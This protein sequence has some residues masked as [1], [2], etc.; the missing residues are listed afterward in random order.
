MKPEKIISCLWGVLLAFLVSF[1]AIA[2]T[3]S[4]FNIRIPLGQAALWCAV[5]AVVCGG[6]F[7]LPLKLV[8]PAVAAAVLG[9]LWRE[10]SLIDS[11]EALLNRLTRQYNRA[12]GWGIIR[13]GFRTADDMEPSMLLVFCIIGAVIA[14]LVAW[15]VCRGKPALPGVLLSFLPVAACFVVTD[16]VPDVKWLYLWMLGVV[17]LILTGKVRRQEE[18]QGNRL[19][20]F[21]APCAAL[22]LLL[23]FAAVP[24]KGYDG[25]KN[26]E[27]MVSALLGS[28]PVQ[29]LMSYTQGNSV[30]SVDSGAVDLRNVGYRMESQAKIMEV[31]AP[32][33]GT[34]Y[35]RGRAMDTYNGISWSDGGNV[36]I[37]TLDWP[38][39]GLESVGEVSVSTRYA[40]R[41]LY[42][43]YYVDTDQL[44]D[45][46]IGIENEK[47]LT[48]Y[49]FPCKV[50]TGAYPVSRADSAFTQEQIDLF[51][52]CIQV[53]E[54]TA[55][56]AVS[57][58]GKL[59]AGTSSVRQ[60]ATNIASYVRNSASYDTATP[61]MPSRD[62][63]FAKWFL[64]ESNT[65]YCVHFATATAVLLQAAGIPARYVTGYMV[66]VQAGQTAEVR[67]D[68]AHAWVE[69][70]QPGFGW[71]VLESTPGDLREQPQ[72]TETVTA[73]TVPEAT[74]QT[75]PDSTT[76]TAHTPV[77]SEKT[78][79]L[80]GLLAA[81]RV[82][83]AITGLVVL[84]EGQHGLRR[85][86]QRKGRSRGST[87]EQAVRCWH[88][89][90]R[91][92]RLLGEQPDKGLFEMAQKAKFSQYTLT[93]QELSQFDDWETAAVG[94]L[95]KRSV[96]HRFWYRI[97]L[98]VY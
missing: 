12:Y 31:T 90:V 91:L 6:C 70:Y 75:A 30:L 13:W 48:S 23:L 51:A 59:T 58:A 27:K 34:L 45:V 33:D 15:A 56:W 67:A 84:L 22:A 86:I 7:A 8:P 29:M 95:K 5:S 38:E 47:K 77:T 4:A 98:A 78:V 42:L 11:V 43:P 87:N 73:A 44:G 49:S 17:V 72:Q 88:H 52:Q 93:Q 9:Y 26:A 35:L 62:R 83:A 55:R 32:F 60:R 71:T 68:Q 66:P 79:D 3:V 64:E 25:Q 54:S 74:E 53:N 50:D 85:Y 57:L 69:Y 82:L 46:S 1:G 80:G 19:C 81:L 21:A 40:H 18:K 10:G 41:M 28:D 96:F 65:G 89:M 92:A 63:D 16:T 37:R 20:A 24:Q 36:A 61:R 97:V 94:R 39:E 14:M 76:A 2:C